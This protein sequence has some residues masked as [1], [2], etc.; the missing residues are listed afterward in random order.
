MSDVSRAFPPD[1]VPNPDEVA[2]LVVGGRVWNDWTSVKVENRFAEAFDVFQFENVERP[3]TVQFVP[4]DAVGVYLGGM[5]AITGVVTVRQVGLDPN[6]HGVQLSGKGRTWFAARGSIIDETGSFD[7]QTFEQVARKLIARFG[8]G[9]EVIGKLD[10]TPFKRLSVEPGEK[11]WDFLENL[12]RPLGIV[13]GSDSIGNFLLIGPHATTFDD[14]IRE[15]GNMKSLK[16]IVSIEEAYSEYL[17]AGQTAADDEQNGAA[18]SQQ[19]AS[20]KGSSPHYSPLLTPAEQPVWT[21]AEILNRARN[22]AV[23]HE[24]AQVQCVVVVYGWKR[25]GGALWRAGSNV[26]VVAPSAPVNAEMSIQ[27]AIFSQDDQ[28][29]TL[30][31]LELVPPFLL[32]GT[33]EFNVGSTEMP[34]DPTTYEK[35]KPAL[36]A[37]SVPQP[38]PLK[39]V[40]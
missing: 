19:R 39:L 4:G 12:A 36:P 11:L 28:S 24:G 7:G 38:P 16:F 22:E 37:T 33:S 20:V 2:T 30:T 3:I 34:A 32:R 15:G 27:S 29:G 40:T 25:P 1:Q 6:N 18:S 5:L 35:D 10:D 9:V 17:V 31:T 8:V 26:H 21:E 23:W 14:T 13:M